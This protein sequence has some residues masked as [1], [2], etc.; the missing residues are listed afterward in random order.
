M[1][2]PDDPKKL[3]LDKEKEEKQSGQQVTTEQIPLEGENAGQNN[4]NQKNEEKTNE[5]EEKDKEKEKKDEN[6]NPGQP[7]QPVQQQKKGPEIVR[8]IPQNN[9]AHTIATYNIP[10]YNSNSKVK[11]IYFFF[12][13]K[14]IKK[15][16][17][18]NSEDL[19]YS[20]KK[21]VKIKL[22][23]TSLILSYNQIRFFFFVVVNIYKKK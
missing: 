5:N 9:I 22:I 21:V 2:P 14:F 11:Y 6:A 3:L 1:K 16:P 17:G 15:N 13:L 8:I 19:K 7:Q 10:L 4:E 18:K 20:Q 23:C 12:C